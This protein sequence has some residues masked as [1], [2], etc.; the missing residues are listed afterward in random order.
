[1]KK[2][3]DIIKENIGTNVYSY[4]V[5]LD[6]SGLVHAENEGS[7][8]EEVD[9]EMD[10]VM[11]AISETGMGIACDTYNIENIELSLGTDHSESIDNN[12][13][14]ESLDA[15]R[16]GELHILATQIINILKTQDVDI[17]SEEL[18]FVIARIKKEFK[19][20]EPESHQRKYSVGTEISQDLSDILNAAMTNYDEYVSKVKDF[21]SKYDTNLQPL[22]EPYIGHSANFNWEDGEELSTQEIQ[23]RWD[24]MLDVI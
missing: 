8:G 10:V 12:K 24:A 22:P 5:K 13:V 1:M 3:T 14:L 19:T 23:L 9:S 16:E 2:I 4:K 11:A 20:S 6:I 17:N 21:N 7:A 18:D 15:D